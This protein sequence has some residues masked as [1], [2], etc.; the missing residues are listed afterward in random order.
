MHLVS[1]SRS[2]SE[3]KGMGL[4]QPIRISR[5]YVNGCSCAEIQDSDLGEQLFGP[6]W[7]FDIKMSAR[8]LREQVDD[9]DN[10]R[11]QRPVGVIK[12]HG[13]PR[14]QRCGKK[15][16]QCNGENEKCD[17]NNDEVREQ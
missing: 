2:T 13:K 8:N 10:Q 1:G 5:V 15:R 7:A 12:N 14:Q 9:A 16:K 3:A 6:M 4:E 17:G 11:S